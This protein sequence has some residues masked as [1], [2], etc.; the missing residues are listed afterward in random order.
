MYGWLFSFIISGRPAFFSKIKFKLIISTTHN[1]HAYPKTDD[2]I[3]REEIWNYVAK[4]D[5][6]L[7]GV[8]ES[9]CRCDIVSAGWL[10]WK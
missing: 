6:F 1:G 10:M 7:D 8:F 2:E 9:G 5:K 4:N 3:G